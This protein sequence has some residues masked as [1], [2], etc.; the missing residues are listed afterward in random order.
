VSE[1]ELNDLREQLRLKDL[2]VKRINRE[3]RTMQVVFDR[4]KQISRSN[5]GMREALALS[6]AKQDRYLF[7]LFD[8]CPDFIML[9][10]P[11]GR[12]AYCTAAFLKA[13]D[14]ADF[15]LVSGRTWREVFA[16]F[17]DAD[18]LSRINA[19][20]A[21]AAETKET[22]SINEDADVSGG[23]NPRSY[24]VQFT[25][26]FD[27][28]GELTGSLVVSHDL[29]ELL[30]AKKTAEEATR[31]KSD[32]LATVSHEIRTPMNAIIGI[33]DIIKKTPLSPEQAAHL[34]NIESSSKLLLGIINDILDFSK[35]EAGKLD[36]V[37][38][39]FDLKEFLARLQSV[40]EVLF[41]QKRLKFACSFADNIPAAVFGDE[42]LINQI[43]TNLLNNALKYTREGAV[44]FTVRLE[45]GDLYNF[46]I[47]DTGIGIKEEDM[48]RL[49]KAFEQ[50]DKIKN[51]K[52][53]G[54]GLGLAITKKLIEA[55]GGAVTVKSKYG[56]GSAFGVKLRIP[57]GTEKDLKKEIRETRVFAAP[58]AKVLLVDDV[59]IN[60]IV[61]AAVLG[62]Y[63]IVPDA[64]PG[65][66]S[67][68][69][70]AAKKEYDLILMDHMMPELDG[71]E[72][73]KRIRALGGRGGKVPVIALTAN[74]VSG[75]EEMFLANGFNAFLAKPIDKNAL[76][77]CL[78]KWL[79]ENL[80]KE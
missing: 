50:M 69:E 40:F 34:N 57:P 78:L 53:V 31:A 21:K 44:T 76:A 14:I 26:V 2:E 60:L 43:L 20:F 38:D 6:K 67:A 63:K 37:P 25:S 54:T 55:M 13:A 18:M 56:E 30:A 42:K 66:L 4:Y 10:D 45:E 35:I 17:A 49:F 33:T 72:A 77:S 19:A 75:A 79:P 36:V 59:D 12:F 48:G 24:E 41:A 3:L 68:V 71:V 1:E 5:E 39:Y 16:K 28:K 52:A 15:S 8:N 27:K 58:E 29:T 80:I 74:A 64:A 22:V 51:K 32:F 65:G 11:E 46:E 62:E 47:S 7:M 23:A 70:M 61:A 9:F 73:V